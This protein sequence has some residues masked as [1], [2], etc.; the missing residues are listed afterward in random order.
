MC[1]HV[2]MELCACVVEAAGLEW[3]VRARGTM[4]LMALESS[5]EDDAYEVG[6]HW[7][8]SGLR[9]GSNE[10]LDLVCGIVGW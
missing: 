2:R 6:W 1:V 5:R 7:I 3:R 8:G 10:A 9:F 4:I